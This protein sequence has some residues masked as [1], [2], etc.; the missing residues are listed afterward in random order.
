MKNRIL[1]PINR[2]KDKFNNM[3][4]MRKYIQLLTFLL[5]VYF[6]PLSAQS[7]PTPTKVQLEWQRMETIGFVHFSVNT[8]TDMEWGYGNESPSIFNPTHLD[9]R[10]WARTFKEAGLKGII[11]TAKHH[12]GFCLWPS[13]Y[14]EHSVKHSP[15][16]NGKGDLVREFADACREYGLEVGLYLSPWDCN[17]PDYG[18]PEY[19]TYFK[20]QLRELLTNY[21]ELFEFWFDGANGGRGY[22]STDSL[23]MRSIAKDYYPWKEIT[24][25]VYELQPNCVVHGGDLANIRWVGNEQGYALE[26]H[27]SMMGALDPKIKSNIQLMTGHANGTVWK[28]SETDVSIRPGWYYHVSEDHKLHSLAKLMDIYYNS[29]GRNSLLLL[30]IPPNQE[31]LIDSNDSLRLVQWR[32]LYTKELSCNLL[33]QK[34]NIASGDS[35]KLKKCM[36]NNANS[37][38]EAPNL[39]PTIEIDFKKELLFNRLMLQEYIPQGQRVKAFSVEYYHRGK[40]NPL[41]EQTT[42]GYKRILRLPETM[43]SRI[44]IHIKDALAVPQISEIQ[45]FYA[46]TQL[47][48]PVIKRKQNGDVY[49]RT[50]S[51]NAMIYYTMDGTVPT[52]HN[53]KLYQEPFIADGSQKIQAVA[54]DGKNKSEISERQFTNSKKRWTTI[55]SKAAGT[56]FDE[57]EYTSWISSQGNKMLVIDLGEIRQMKGFSYLPDQARYSRGIV[58]KYEIEISSDNQHWQTVKVPGEF[59]NIQNNPVRQEVLFDI[60]V[61]GRYFRFKA[62]SIAG[63]QNTLGIAE[64]D[65]L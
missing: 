47:D 1:F 64:F 28:P 11:L 48:K 3:F 18:K 2:N 56:V 51:K 20:N 34:M 13:A 61:Q 31:G 30:N 39:T 21:G 10:Q 19:I 36:D 55:P 16:K 26:E 54:I 52:E 46:E 59:A 29:V 25:M 44:R 65:I 38:W 42:I 50:T 14:T 40:W 45:L 7:L 60:P 53:G 49:I 32:Q 17:H 43:A 63:Q 15:W 6:G 12:D 23:H 24:E 37:Y 58:I 27:W 4:T 41:A 8:Y 57:Q 5:C 9:C 33:N 62:I 22:Y 35:K